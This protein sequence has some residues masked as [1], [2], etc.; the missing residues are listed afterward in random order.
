MEVLNVELHNSFCELFVLRIAKNL[1]KEGG[2][3]GIYFGKE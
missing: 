3:F 1:T 2:R